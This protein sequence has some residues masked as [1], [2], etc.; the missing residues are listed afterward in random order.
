[1][2]LTFTACGNKNSAAN[3]IPNTDSNAPQTV[4]L[5]TKQTTSS[6]NGAYTTNEYT[7]NDQGITTKRII[8][9]YN[10]NGEE[11]MRSE[12]TYDDYGNRTQKTTNASIYTYEYNDK[13]QVIKKVLDGGITFYYTYDQKGYLTEESVS[14][15]SVERTPLYTYTYEAGNLTKATH[16]DGWNVTIAYEDG[17]PVTGDDSRGNTYTYEVTSVTVSPER[18]ME[19]RTAQIDLLFEKPAKLSF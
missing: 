2:L 18:A 11:M 5:I 17:K 8:T 9:A 16:K 6:T 10:A 15:E 7:Y 4:W 1:M 13:N 3:N 12:E 14:A 19:L